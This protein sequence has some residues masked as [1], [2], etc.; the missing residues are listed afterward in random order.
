MVHLL[1]GQAAARVL[2]VPMPAPCL[3]QHPALLHQLRKRVFG[4]LPNAT[5]D[6]DNSTRASKQK[7]L[8]GVALRSGSRV[9]LNFEHLLR[10]IATTFNVNAAESTIEI[11]R[12][13]STLVKSHTFLQQAALFR[14][15]DILFGA[16]GA[17][18]ANMLWMRPG[19][20]VIEVMSAPDGNM[21]YFRLSKNI[22]LVHH[23]VLHA[24]G[25][26]A[27]FTVDTDEVTK[28]FR[29]AVERILAERQHRETE[30]GD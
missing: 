28:H 7:I 4:L 22:G 24:K 11:M 21:C 20:H 15:V 16:H 6:K 27:S 29:H 14:R 30:K 19:T 25:K 1:H 9:I 17:N 5:E 12:I 26:Q 3:D 10:H 8:V 23:L 13:P 2:V 18:L